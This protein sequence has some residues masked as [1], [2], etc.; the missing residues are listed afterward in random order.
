MGFA[1]CALSPCWER[2]AVP[3]HNEWYTGVCSV[4]FFLNSLFLQD[5]FSAPSSGKFLKRQSGQK[6]I[7]CPFDGMLGLCICL[8]PCLAILQLCKL[9][10]AKNNCF[11]HRL[12]NSFWTLQFPPYR[13][14]SFEHCTLLSCRISFTSVSK[15]LSAIPTAYVFSYPWT[16]A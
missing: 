15:F 1:L 3:S 6:I 10:T 8:C 11:V 5:S 14:N 2:K 12:T 9:K 13:N 4:L 16:Q 7:G